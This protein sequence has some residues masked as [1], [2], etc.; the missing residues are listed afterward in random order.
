MPVLCLINCDNSTTNEAENRHELNRI[1]LSIDHRSEYKTGS[2]LLL[3][4]LGQHHTH[5]VKQLV[6]PLRQVLN[7]G[8][9]PVREMPSDK[10]KSGAFHGEAKL[11]DFHGAGYT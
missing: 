6:S 5:T 8:P 9:A 4:N 7:L 1:D 3:T 10:G 2:Q 11:R